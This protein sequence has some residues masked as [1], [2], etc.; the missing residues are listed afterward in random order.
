MAK[1]SNPDFK[2]LL[3]ATKN[4]KLVHQGIPTKGNIVYHELMNVREKLKKM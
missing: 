4:A 2:D 3:L 1:F